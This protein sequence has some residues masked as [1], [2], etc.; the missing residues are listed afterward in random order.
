MTAVTDMVGPPPCTAGI[1][2]ALIR[3]LLSEIGTRKLRSP[4][5]RQRARYRHKRS[6]TPITPR[7]CSVIA[8]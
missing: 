8:F 7:Q 6:P 5:D 3:T 1:L 4:T 2:L